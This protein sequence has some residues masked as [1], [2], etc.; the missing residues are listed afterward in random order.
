MVSCVCH[1]TC[2]SPF[3]SLC[4]GQHANDE[5]T[6]LISQADK[7]GD[8]RVSALFVYV[9]CMCLMSWCVSVLRS[10]CL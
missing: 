2:L 10:V 1:C 3:S 4:V 9:L 8:G 7:D 6:Y 5:A